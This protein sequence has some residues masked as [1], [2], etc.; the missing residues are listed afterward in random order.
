MAVEFEL[1]PPERLLYHTAAIVGHAL[2]TVGADA[3]S[4][5]LHHH[6]AVAVVDVDKGK[7]RGGQRVEE[8]LLGGYVVCH[9]LVEVEMVVGEVAEHPSGKRKPAD[10]IL[11]HGMTADLDKGIL[12]AGIHHAAEHTVEFKGI[13]GGMGGGDF[14]LVYFVDNGGEQSS[15][16]TVAAEKA[17]QKGDSSGFAVGTCHADETQLAGR[18]AVV[19][20][21]DDA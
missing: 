12:A 21:G 9:S 5:V 4:G 3:G 20:V 19:I 2:Q 8:M 14:L 6:R 10:A 1:H 7:G 11:H 15:M 13:G 16:V 17:V 18:M